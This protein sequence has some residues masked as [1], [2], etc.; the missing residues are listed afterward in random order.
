MDGESRY[1]WTHAVP[2]DMDFKK[3]KITIFY[4]Q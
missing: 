4:N 2:N 3:N 1:L